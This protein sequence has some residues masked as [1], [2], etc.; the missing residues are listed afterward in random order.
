MKF[1]L[2]TTRLALAFCL[3]GV[4]SFGVEKLIR[5]PIETD[6]GV[7][8]P[9]FLQSIGG[10]LRAPI[11]EGNYVQ[12]YIN[13]TNIFP[14]ML[15]AISKAERTISFENFI[16]KSGD[17]SDRFIEALTERA[18]A[19]VKVHCIVDGFGALKFKHPDQERLRNAGVELEIFNPIR[20]WNF[21]KWN[22]RTHRKILVIDGKVGFTGGICISDAWDGDALDESHWRDT[23]FRLEGPVV[24]EFQGVFM[25]NWIRTRSEVLQGTNYFPLPEIKGS[26]LAQCFKSGPQDGAENAR[27]L[28]LYSIAAARKT[29]RLSESYFVPDNLA[30]EMLVAAR[31]RGVKVEVITPGI[32]SANIVRRAARSR[33]DD[34]MAAGVDFYEFQPARYHCK[35]MIV[36]DIWVTCG[37][38]N[39]DDRSFR[40]NDE[41]NVNI[42]DREFAAR[43]IAIFEQDKTKCLKTERKEFRH[44]KW[45]IRSVENFCGLFRGLL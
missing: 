15:Q 25:D 10:L 1:L 20:P 38:V 23:E 7:E 33:W 41:A 24:T 16:W 18:R 5:V 27:L 35:V 32:I 36:D 19:G 39:F 14:A 4:S 30:V 13:G 28:Y 42:Y 9:A 3:F 40:I 11:L 6:Y 37:S 26:A 17:L 45:Y 31:K 22:H 8:D 43:Q 12:E 44:R 34:L 2:S 29:I 21:L